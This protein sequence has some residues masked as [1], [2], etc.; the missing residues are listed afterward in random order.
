MQRDSVSASPIPPLGC[1]PEP[2]QALLQHLP[3]VRCLARR[4]HERLPRNIDIHDLVSA[5]LVGLMEASAKFDPA[6]EIRFASYANFR[7]RGAILDSLRT[8]DWAPRALRRKGR[9]ARDAIRTLTFKLGRTPSE[10]EVAAELKM[11]LEDYQ[12][13]L[14]SLDGLEIGTLHRQSEDGS[15]DDEV[16]Y[17]PGPPEDDPLFRCMREEIAKRL[18]AAIQNL[19]ERE[20]QVT[21]L[22]Y[23]EEMSIRE[24]GMVLGLDLVRVSRIRTSAVL[25]LR[26]ALSD[27]SPRLTEDHAHV[28]LSCMKPPERA[29]MPRSAA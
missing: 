8:S 19:N 4:I 10:D 26:A 9:E 29:S 3:M 12:Q 13:L 6:R 22:Y 28:P 23:Y 14:G 7:V 20:R 18:T 1:A 24:I 16:E 15:S 2:E 21:T 17:A 25:H 27:L 5:G 11:S